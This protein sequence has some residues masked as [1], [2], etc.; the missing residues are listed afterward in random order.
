MD[1]RKQ[2]PEF[3]TDRQIM[4]LTASKVFAGSD[5]TA[6]ALRTIFYY[7]LRQPETM[8]KWME[9]LE[10]ASFDREG[11]II[12]WEEG[13]ELPFLTAVVEEALR[14]SPAVGFILE[15]IVPDAGLEVCGHLIPAGTVSDESAW[16]LHRKQSIFGD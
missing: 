7:L 16:P 15:R 11:E 12:G 1:E 4:G 8:R 5:S 6:I 14:I 9:E 10:G 3:I 2:D 13:R